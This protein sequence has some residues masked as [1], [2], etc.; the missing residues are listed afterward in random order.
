MVRSPR[1]PRFAGIAM[2]VVCGACGVDHAQSGD[3]TVADRAPVAG[4]DLL[5]TAMN[6]P[7][8]VNV[9]VNDFDPDGDALS[10][11]AAPTSAHGKVAIAG[12][13]ATYT[14]ATGYV[15]PDQFTYTLSDDRGKTATG[16]VNVMVQP[17]TPGCTIIAAGPATGTFGEVIQLTATAMC[18]TGAAQVQWYHKVN[19]SYAVVQP[20]GALQTLDFT[21][22][23]VGDNLFYATAR[24][25]GGT[26]PQAMSNLVPVRTVDNTPQCTQ[27][28]M[29]AP[30]NAQTL[31][32][33]APATLTAMATCPASAVAEYQFWVKPTSAATWQVLPGYTTDSASWTPP[34]AGTWSIRAVARS[35]GSHVPYQVASMSVTVTA[36]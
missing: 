29:V 24:T 4:N 32:V 36:N 11:A 12:P 16:T 35:T 14:P 17:V 3:D 1:A 2:V 9:L 8:T 19:S 33:G 25:E 28:K 10:V 5:V 21:V 18:N 31:A 15:G 30:I 13:V 7:G 6:R 20:F 27:V 23:L 34:T 26:L 22:D